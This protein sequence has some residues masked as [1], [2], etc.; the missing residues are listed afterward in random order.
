[1]TMKKQ[2]T[3]KRVLILAGLAIVAG[4]A[5]TRA[6]AEELKLSQM[7]LESTKCPF[8]SAEDKLAIGDEQQPV[9]PK[10]ANQATSIAAE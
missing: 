10:P 5:L 2:I 8:S 7:N 4:T 3:W 1:M 9:A 6:H